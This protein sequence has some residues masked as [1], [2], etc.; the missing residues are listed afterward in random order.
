MSARWIILLTVS[1]ALLVGCAA[2]TPPEKLYPVGAERNALLRSGLEPMKSESRAPNEPPSPP[3]AS[4]LRDRGLEGRVHRYDVFWV[5]RGAL[6]MGAN[7]DYV[8][9]D[10]RDRVVWVMRR[11]VD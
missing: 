6:G 3:V 1:S 10:D 5:P 11:F 8:F 4:T 9:Y 7:W 2:G